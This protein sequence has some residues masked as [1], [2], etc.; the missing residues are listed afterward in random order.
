MCGIVGI[1]SN[2]TPVNPDTLIC[3]RDALI[4]RGPDDC[5]LWI[6][7]NGLVGLGHRRLSIIDLSG[8]GRQPMESYDRRFVITFNGE[9][10]N[11]Q[12][13]REEL[14]GKYS[15]KSGTDTE[16]LLYSYAEWGKECLHKL[17]G[18]F[19]FAVWDEVEKKL[20]AARD[21]AGEKPFY[22]Y[23]RN[24]EFVFASE[25]K[26]I[27]LYDCFEKRIDYRSLIDYLTFGF[28]CA[29]KSIW[30]DCYKLPAGHY[31]EYFPENGKLEIKCYWDIDLTPD[32]SKSESFWIEG[33]KE[34]LRESVKL[35]LI[36]DVPLGAFLSGGVDSSA[37]V[38]VMKDYKPELKT[39][40][41]GFKNSGK[42][43][44]LPYAINVSK[45]V[46]TDHKNIYVTEDDFLELFDEMCWFYD[47]PFGDYSYIPT[48]CVSRLAKKE[49]TVAISGDGGD[50]LFGGYSKY[51]K[52]QRIER[53][54]KFMP[55]NFIRLIESLVGSLLSRH[56][57]IKKGLNMLKQHQN[58]M[59]LIAN[60]GNR[61][62]NLRAMISDEEFMDTLNNYNPFDPLLEILNNDKI[63]N[64]DIVTKARYLDFKWYLCDDILTKVDRAS[65]AIS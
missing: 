17:R 57:R 60:N 24:D 64:L 34:H 10:Y 44:E 19:A 47:E 48:Y 33:I 13:I 58:G 15:F 14:K 12:E 1:L 31:L 6:N 63:K 35:M 5:G 38:S 36:S 43:N 49:V 62:E 55:K 26:A 52:L 25:P 46:G 23:Y 40:S 32:Y 37:V 54:R 51:W 41:I 8:A 16:V 59:I 22:Y 2:K 30:K 65:M 53:I 7:K 45:K 29:P 4:H 9:I 20:F 21:R 11:F 28:I 3:M 18:I 39:F 27:T 42:F 56:S 50:E 61:S